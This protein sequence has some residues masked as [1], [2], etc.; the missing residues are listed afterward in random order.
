MAV[1][2]GVIVNASKN[3]SRKTQSLFAG[4]VKFGSIGLNRRL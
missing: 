2:N 1:L 3:R 4:N